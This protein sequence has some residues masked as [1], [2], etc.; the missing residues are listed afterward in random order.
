MVN[1]MITNN[2]GPADFRAVY[3]YGPAHQQLK[4][5][6]YYTDLFRNTVTFP[7]KAAIFPAASWLSAVEMDLVEKNIA[8][9]ETAG[10][11]S[12]TLVTPDGGEING[13]HIKA[14]DFKANCEKYYNLV[15]VEEKDGT[16]SQYLTIKEE[17]CTVKEEKDLMDDHLRKILVP[18]QEAEKFVKTV[19]SLGISYTQG[20]F[21]SKAGLYGSVINLGKAPPPDVP[22]LAPDLRGSSPTAIIVGGSGMTYAGYKGLAA[23]YLLRGMNVLMVDFR[24]YGASK[25]TPTD[26]KTKMDLETAYQYLHQKEHVKNEDIVVHGHCLGGGPASDLAARRE[27]VNVILDR[28]FAD[29]REVLRERLP[30]IGAIVATALPAVVNYNVAENVGKM[31]GH[32]AIAMDIKDGTISETQS[33][34]QINSLPEPKTRQGDEKAK[35][36]KLID[37]NRG[38]TGL[39]TDNA[40]TAAQF[41]NFLEQ[42]N[43]RRKL[44]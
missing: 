24:G 1:F 3:V 43:L 37:S 2:S 19:H 30:W 25:G 26:D 40:R 15:V 20:E 33:Y 35:V 34:G 9:L 8:Q 18:N 21:P 6:G 22:D 7:L 11:K 31:K 16:K 13:M 14:S 10:G 23:S 27:G 36:Y 17:F 41:T 32:I 38:H 29:Y 44:F 28:T 5:V 12:L 4:P 39:W 42:S